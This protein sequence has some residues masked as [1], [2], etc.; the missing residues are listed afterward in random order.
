MTK[1][2]DDLCPEVLSNYTFMPSGVKNVALISMVKNEEDIILENLIWHFAIG[3]RKFVITDNLSSDSTRQKI[4]YFA[5]LTNN[6]AQVFIIDD[7]IFEHIQSKIITSSYHLARIVW[8]SVKW[9]FPVDADEFWITTKPLNEI[10]DKLERSKYNAVKTNVSR[11]GPSDNDYY[12]FNQDAKFYEKFHYHTSGFSDKPDLPKIA[13]KAK[14]NLEID[15]GNHAAK[16][17]DSRKYIEAIDSASFGLTMREFPIRS[18]EHAHMKYFNSMQANL[19]GK[20]LGVLNAGY[21]THWDAYAEYIK[22]FADKAGEVKFNETFI[23]ESQSLDDLLPI[24]RAFEILN[25]VVSHY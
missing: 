2:N 10:I 21:S 16:N 8:P 14:A 1:D 23:D 9:I 25:D 20:K 6:H 18:S 4:Q 24:G 11:Y 17:F 3:F 7:P 13:L 22:E 12:L 15:Q 19:K 5:N